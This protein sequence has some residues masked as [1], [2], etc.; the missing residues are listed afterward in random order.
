MIKERDF[1]HLTKFPGETGNI[2]DVVLHRF[3][4]IQ[5]IPW[6]VFA[7]ILLAYASLVTGFRPAYLAI[8]YAF[9]IADW[10]LIAALPR[11]EISFG[12]PQPPVLILAVLR[13]VFLFFPFPF[14]I[15]LQIIGTVL[16]VYAFWIEPQRL[17]VTYQQFHSPKIKSQRAIR[18]LHLGDLH[19][20]RSTRREKRL[21]QLV[22]ELKPDIILFSGDLLSL[23][24]LHDP[25]SWA[26]ARSVLSKLHAPHGIFLVTGSPAVDLPKIMPDLLKGLPLRWLQDEKITVEFEED[27]V[28]LIGMT[29]TH[30]P[31][32]DGNKLERLTSPKSNRFTVLL[33]HSPDL[34]PA[35]ARVG[36]DLQ[37]SGHTHGGQ[38]RLPGFGAIFTGSLYGKA[39][40]AG[41][42]Q[43]DNLTVYVTR[44]IGMEGAA[45]PRVRFL[46]PPEIILWELSGRETR[47]S[48]NQGD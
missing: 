19:I 42:K 30:R 38:V 18:L 12:P 36:I 32:I 11:A 9:I 33:Y 34:A 20:E 37:L 16:V 25:Q 1:T 39:F 45:A 26:D 40:E 46:C 43:I 8:H 35:A 15:L 47:E 2:F 10:G 24:R 23:S 27:R 44:G 28:D 14:F 13:S 22:E 21:L 29:C 5:R 3:E 17:T 48:L 6:P 31:H 7:L 41:R 4:I